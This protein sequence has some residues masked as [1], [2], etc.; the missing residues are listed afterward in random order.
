MQELP[1][2]SSRASSLVPSA[3]FEPAILGLEVRCLIHWATRANRTRSS[4]HQAVA[5]H[6]WMEVDTED[7]L[8]YGGPYV[9]WRCAACLRTENTPEWTDYGRHGQVD[10]WSAPPSEEG[11]DP[12]LRVVYE[13]MES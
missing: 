10:K 2:I 6:V 3:G 5:K 9:S 4:V 8:E 12:E 11:C 1:H 13:I 7:Y